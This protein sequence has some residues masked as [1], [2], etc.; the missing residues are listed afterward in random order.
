[1]SA[2]REISIRATH[3]LLLKK[4]EQEQKL[5]AMLVNKL[6]DPER[7][8]C[9]KVEYHLTGLIKAHPN[10]QMYIAQE[11]ERVVLMAKVGVHAQ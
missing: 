9:A 4:P 10:M 5:L 11:V 2:F 8:L 1:V 7:S 6:G 3:V